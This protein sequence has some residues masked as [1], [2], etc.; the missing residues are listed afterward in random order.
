MFYCV[1]CVYVRRY[2]LAAY[3]YV[4]LEYDYK[5]FDVQ[6]QPIQF[7]SQPDDHYTV[8]RAD[9]TFVC[10]VTSFN[11]F[12][13]ITWFFNNTVIKTGSH[14][15]NINNDGH[16]TSTLI[17]RNVSTDDYGDYHCCINEWNTVIRS[18]SGRLY[19]NILQYQLKQSV[20]FKQSNINDTDFSNFNKYSHKITIISK[21]L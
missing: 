19:G 13:N 4:F 18:R 12:P 2:T 16:T 9:V 8:P 3:D 1:I 15:N 7:L 10:S 21:D 14:Y 11:G 17:I 6:P 20:Y 5:T